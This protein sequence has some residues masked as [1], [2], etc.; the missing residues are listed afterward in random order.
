LH[1]HRLV[2]GSSEMI[3]A[4]RFRVYAAWWQ[5]LERV[6]IESISIAELPSTGDDGRHP[7]VAMSVSGNRG[8][9]LDGQDDRVEAGSWRIAGKYFRAH[10]SEK[11]AP[12]L[13]NNRVV[14]PKKMIRPSVATGAV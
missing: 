11:G 9:R 7:I 4:T 1:E 5:S 10:T 13:F 14:D 8:V 2:T 12:D 3:P 6:L